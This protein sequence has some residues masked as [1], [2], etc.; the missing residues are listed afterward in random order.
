MIHPWI[1]LFDVD[2]TLL[3]VENTFMRPLLRGIVDELEISY[4]GIETDSFSGRTDRDIFSSFLVNHAYDQRLYM[5]LK[6]TYLQRLSVNLEPKHVS[7][8]AF[9]D[10]AISYFSKEGFIIGLLTGNFPEAAKIK[11]EGANI[12]LDYTISA[13]G[14]SFKDRNMLPK[15]AK[16][17]ATE[18]LNHEVDPQRCVIVGDTPKD[19]LCAKNNGMKSVA[20]ATGMYSKEILK[21]YEPDLILDS[22]KNPHYWFQEFNP[23][24][25]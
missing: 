13:F 21:T 6:K 1:I 18:M 22:L 15:L 3:N 10:E 12:T 20:V 9:V 11:L 17:K 5:K 7:K 23:F 4:E 16:Q 25:S 14:D 2:G 19:I 8:L 24:V